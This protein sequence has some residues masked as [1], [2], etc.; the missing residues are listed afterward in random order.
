MASTE[1]KQY[2]LKDEQMDFE[3]QC[4][5]GGCYYGAADAGEIL[6]TAD[7]IKEGDYESWYQEWCATAERV[8]GIA[9]QCTAAGN[10]VSARCAYLR[11]AGYYS[12]AISMIDG[13]KDPSRGVPTWKRHLACWDEFCSRLVPPAEKV[14]IPYEETPMPGYFFVPDG[15][16]G[17]WPTI[18]FNN[19][20]DGTT[21]GMWTFGVAGALQ[22]GYAALVFDGPGQ[23]SMLWLHD[24]P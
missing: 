17:P 16:G 3:V 4:I 24:V 21:S 22:R 15:S 5:L 7:R 18:I 13:T 20:S 12:A 2:F 8:G 6:A 11:A 10:D 19:G 14:D 23:N 1:K 9:E